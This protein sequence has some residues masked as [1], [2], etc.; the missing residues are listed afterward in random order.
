MSTKKNISPSV[1]EAKLRI[2]LYNKLSR[3]LMLL[4]RDE[5]RTILSELD[6]YV[7]L[8]QSTD[9]MK[10][11]LML[12]YFICVKEV[13]HYLYKTKG[14]NGF[15]GINAEIRQHINDVFTTILKEH[16]AD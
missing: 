3:L 5:V 7:K 11:E 2:E 1:D 6:K 16:D 4:K 14:L 12:M 9:T 10:P 8:M 13:Y 15:D